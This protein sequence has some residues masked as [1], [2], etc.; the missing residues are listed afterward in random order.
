MVGLS[1][2]LTYLLILC[3]ITTA[4][5]VALVIYGNALD[6][7]ESEEIYINK[8]EEEMMASEQP[9]LIGK[10]HR[11]ARAILVLAVISG[12][13]LLASAGIWVYI[14]LYRS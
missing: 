2:I 14:G 6:T 13:T 12:A 5:L 9:V 8:T 4:A 3:G 1:S 10:M 7:R 11:L